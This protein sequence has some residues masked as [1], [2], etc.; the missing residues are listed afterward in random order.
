[1][2]I[3]FGSDIIALRLSVSL[4]CCLLERITCSFIFTSKLPLLGWLQVY[5][6]YRSTAHSSFFTFLSSFLLITS[7]FFYKNAWCTPH[8][9][10]SARYH[11]SVFLRM[12]SL[13]SL[14]CHLNK[15]TK[16]ATKSRH[17]EN[18]SVKTDTLFLKFRE[19]SCYFYSSLD[20]F[21]KMIWI[22]F[23]IW[24]YKLCIDKFVYI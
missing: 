3:H 7:F 20:P 19:I 2:K 12:Q 1:M 18:I 21:V 5:R 24:I 9:L 22:N 8:Q 13:P 14:E 15:T 16:S 17:W 10:F 4:S 23:C 11:I 6:F